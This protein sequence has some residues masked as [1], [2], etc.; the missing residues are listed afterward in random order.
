MILSHQE[1]SILLHDVNICTL[2][3]CH[4]KNLW[5]CFGICASVLDL[6]KCFVIVQVFCDCASVLE[7]VQVFWIC[8]SG[9]SL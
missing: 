1:I 9:L 8:G 7:F 2:F 4:Q 3:L 5:K 6:W